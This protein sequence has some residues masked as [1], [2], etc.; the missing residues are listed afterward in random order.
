MTEKLSDIIQVNIEEELQKSY[1]DYSMSVIVGRALPD[2][3]DGLK[4]VHRRVLFSMYKNNQTHQQAK[5]KSAR[6]VGDVIGKYHPHGDTAV[7]DTMV[8]MAQ[9]FSMRYTLIEGQG[10]FGSIDGDSPAAMRYTEVRMQKITDELLTDLDKETVDFSPNYDGK[11][12]IPDVLPTKLP[13]FLINGSS[14]IAVGMATNSPP[15]NLTEVLNGCLAFLDNEEISLAELMQHIPGPDFPTGAIINGTKGIVDAYKTGQGKIYVRAKA[16]VEKTAKDREQIIITELPYQVNKKRLIEKITELVNEDKIDGIVDI[17]DLNDKDN[18]N[19]VKIIIDIKKDANGEVVLNHLYNLTQ[20][21]I[22]FGINFVALDHGQPKLFNLKNIISAFITHRREITTRRFIYELRKLRERAHI[23][24]SLDTALCNI[25]EIIELIRNSKTTAEARNNLLSKGWNVG[26]VK[27]ILD[28]TSR[29]LGLAEHYG[30]QKDDKYY[31]SPVQAQAILDMRLQRLT[32]LEYDKIIGEYEECLAKIKKLM[33]ILADPELLKAI[34]REELTEIKN[35]FGDS[36]KTEILTSTLELTSEDLIANEDVVVTMSRAG[37]IKYQRLSDYEAQKRGGKGKLATSMKADDCIEQLVVTKTH[38]TVLFFSTR[39]RIYQLKA[40]QLPLASR[41]ARGTPI[42]NFLPLDT[43]K[44][45]K[46]TTILPIRNFGEDAFV[47]M[48]TASGLVKKVN[49]KDFA[50]IRTNGII[51]VNLKDGDELI[52]VKITT[53]ESDV[54]L[55]T[56]EGRVI[57]FNES[58]I[59]ASG[60]NSMGVRGIKIAGAND[61]VVSLLVLNNTEGSILTL[62]ENG[63]GKRTL[64]DEY[65]VKGRGGLG[66]LSIKV[67]KRNGNVVDAQQVMEADEL[68][69]ITDNANLVRTRVQEIALLGRNTMGVRVMRTKENEHLV[70]IERIEAVEED[71]Q[72]TLI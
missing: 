35:K 50:N 44:N 6:V 15:H 60:R 42:V 34:I 11:E 14:G 7:Y 47:L 19:A 71:S 69:L 41:N 67:N 8:R 51:A 70:S 2:V 61:K 54:M 68:M 21:Q 65:P 43:E 26:R 10:N 63:Y 36:R 25:D 13:N 30:L 17:K 59:R 40:Y 56:S 24:E 48:A 62:T 46:I 16:T 72:E 18:P 32:G 37:Y 9:T 57:R 53:G 3:R 22:T 49:I 66:V 5:V 33:A 27:K 29:P 28:R 52:G 45:E 38:D 1:L 4:P 23:L 58:L 64:V 12:L 20:M 31:L 39:G 55:F